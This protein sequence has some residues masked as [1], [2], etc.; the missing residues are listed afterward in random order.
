MAS[1]AEIRQRVGEELG[2]VPIQQ[3]LEAQDQARIDATFNETYEFLKEKGMAGW[4]AAG[5]VPD[6]VVPYLALYME[7]MLLTGY[8]VPDTRAQR[9]ITAA[10]PG[11]QTALV[12]IGKMVT[13]EYDDTEE[14]HDF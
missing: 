12:M 6:K 1:K 2:L 14:V 8:S 13:Q 11:G 5:P 10:G 7:F 9:I 3:A 4:P